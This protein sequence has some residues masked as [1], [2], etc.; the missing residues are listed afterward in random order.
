MNNGLLEHLKVFVAI[1]QARSLTAASIATDIG[2]PTIS[3]QL[4]TLEKH[5]GCRLFQ[6]STRAVSLTE[7]GEIYLQ[8]ALRM[9][10][11]NEQAEAAVQQ[12]S[13]KLRGRLRVACSNAFG[14]KLLIPTLAQ[15]QIRHPQLHME[16]VLSDQLSQLVE[17]RVDVAFRTAAL[18][19]S[20]LVARA[21]GVSRRI[22][23]ASPDYLRRHGPVSEPA[24]LQ[25]HQ[26]I[27][28]S[29]AEQPR[30]WSFAGPHGKVSVHVQGRLTLSTVDALQDAVL[31]S[32]GVAIMPEWFWGR[33]RLDGQVVQ[34][35][36]DF[37]LPEQTIH[38]LTSAR[39]GGGSK[40]R[41]FVDYVEQTL[42]A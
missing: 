29:G 25:N 18:K 21:I 23:V 40:V 12:G 22:V 34:L 3:R 37:K 31:A 13:T 17:D 5:L 7:Q 16:L 20:S 27:V 10:E 24:D 39:Q 33:E 2:Q 41:Q 32:L 1:A 14:R 28:F 38:A 6:R 15:W 8:H 9:L 42:R 36:A 26:C 19:E 30:F 11:L 4:A 35:L